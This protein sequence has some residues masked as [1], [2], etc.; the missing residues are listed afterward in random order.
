[1]DAGHCI[2]LCR[3]HRRSFSGERMIIHLGSQCFGPLGFGKTAEDIEKKI[4]NAQA[5][6]FLLKGD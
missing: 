3:R 5:M 4:A 6:L 2:G 1:M